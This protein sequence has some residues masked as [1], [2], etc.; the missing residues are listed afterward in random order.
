MDAIFSSEILCSPQTTVFY[1]QKTIVFL[2]TVMRITNPVHSCKIINEWL[3]GK[4][5]KGNAHALI[6]NNILSLFWR[7]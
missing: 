7:V 6:Q 1:N 4:D 2:V 5:L 3:I